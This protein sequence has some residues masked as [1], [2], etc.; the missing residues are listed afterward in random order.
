MESVNIT[1]DEIPT[2]TI[3]VSTLRTAFERCTPYDCPSRGRFA[4]CCPSHSWILETPEDIT[5]ERVARILVYCLSD[6]ED[7]SRF[8]L[9]F[10]GERVASFE[11]IQRYL[12]QAFVKT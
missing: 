1:I 4:T 12:T 9:Y 10:T 6:S 5:M 7:L 3:K 11:V 2:K 8:A